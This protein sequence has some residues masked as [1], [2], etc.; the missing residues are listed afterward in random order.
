MVQIRLGG[1]K[2]LLTLMSAEQQ[3][4]YEGKE[5]VLR[6]SMVKALPDPRYAEEPSL[7]VVDLLHTDKLRVGTT[8]SSE[9]IIAMEHNGVPIETFV[10]LS[11]EGLETLRDA[12]IPEP[13]NGETEE[14][15]MNRI[16]T[17]CYR[18]GG[19]GAEMKKRQCLA[20]GGSTRIAGLSW[21]DQFQDDTSV[22]ES[23]E[24]GPDDDPI[25][26]YG[27]CPYSGQSESM[28]ER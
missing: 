25:E 6:D 18:Q 1:S 23:S 10:R 9:A 21:F 20:A 8:L 5:V 17:A 14:D 28:A 2:G 7:F 16:I 22:G 27:I 19:V 24:D 11:D 4:Q 15:M 13:I 12:F 3:A 26:R